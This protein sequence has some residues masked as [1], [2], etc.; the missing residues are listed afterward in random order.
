MNGTGRTAR[1]GGMRNAYDIFYLKRRDP[2]KELDVD[3]RMTGWIFLCEMFDRSKNLDMLPVPEVLFANISP[4]SFQLLFHLPV[5][6][7]QD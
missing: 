2:L 1:M 5:K 3:G 6:N 7:L 4:F